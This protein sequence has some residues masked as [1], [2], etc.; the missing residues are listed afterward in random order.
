VDFCFFVLKPSD[1]WSEAMPINLRPENMIGLAGAQPNLRAK[2]L[3][4]V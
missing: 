1:G 2:E 3:S 4:A